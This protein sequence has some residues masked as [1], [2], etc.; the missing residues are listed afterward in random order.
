MNIIKFT[1]TLE[2][3]D[4]CIRSESLNPFQSSKNMIIMDF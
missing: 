3:E 4:T 1:F 2:C